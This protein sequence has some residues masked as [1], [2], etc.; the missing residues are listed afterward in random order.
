[1]F[2]KTGEIKWIFRNSDL[3]DVTRY[4]II[5]ILERLVFGSLECTLTSMGVER[6][7][8]VWIDL[9]KIFYLFR[10]VLRVLKKCKKITLTIIRPWLSFFPF[11]FPCSKGDD[12]DGYW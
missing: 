11:L 6:I 3:I 1:M 12:N 4:M 5:E 10:L 2:L 9:F 7:K 8:N